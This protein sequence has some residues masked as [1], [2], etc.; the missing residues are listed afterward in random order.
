MVEQ[1]VGFTLV[2]SA[3]ENCSRLFHLDSAVENSHING[4]D[5]AA[6]LEA[7]NELLHLCSIRNEMPFNTFNL[8]LF[9]PSAKRKLAMA[10]NASKDYQLGPFGSAMTVGF[11]LS[12]ILSEGLLPLMKCR[13]RYVKVGRAH[14]F[15]C[16][17]FTG[18]RYRIHHKDSHCNYIELPQY[19][20]AV[21]KMVSA[22]TVYGHCRVKGH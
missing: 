6:Q 11:S 15:R 9:G 12:L 4:K 18:L 8:S 2:Y 10:Y 22:C 14:A 13:L 17:L 5:K 21:Q 20:D 1:Y 7:K 16:R 19:L 3:F